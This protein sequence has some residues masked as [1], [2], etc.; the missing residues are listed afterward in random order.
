MGR[1][2]QRE[3][4]STAQARTSAITTQTL[5][6][7][8]RRGAGET[9]E[10]A[11]ADVEAWC[12]EVRARALQEASDALLALSQERMSRAPGEVETMNECMLLHSASNLVR[13]L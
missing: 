4:E 6:D 5:I 10:Q 1:R 9:G 3:R 12:R 11:Q 8:Y 2:G 13:S 7:R